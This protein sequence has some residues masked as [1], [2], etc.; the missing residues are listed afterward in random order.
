V[1]G[2]CLFRSGKIALENDELK[3]QS[4]DRQLAPQEEERSQSDDSNGGESEEHPDVVTGPPAAAVP[5]E[6]NV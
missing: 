1:A 6:H 5:L 3:D 2:I 4:I